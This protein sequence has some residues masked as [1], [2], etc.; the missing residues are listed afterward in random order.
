MTICNKNSRSGSGGSGR[1]D[2]RRKNR[3]SLPSLYPVDFVSKLKT[4]FS[5]PREELARTTKL[6]EARIQVGRSWLALPHSHQEWQSPKTMSPHPHL[7]L[8]SFLLLLLNT[9]AMMI[10]RQ[11]P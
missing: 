8:C 2:S 3:M 5:F 10:S 11:D 7:H 1:S 6:N 9:E 4:K